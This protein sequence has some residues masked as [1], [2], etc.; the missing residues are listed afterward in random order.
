MFLIDME[1]WCV[2]QYESAATTQRT[3]RRSICKRLVTC[4]TFGIYLRVV[5]ASEQAIEDESMETNALVD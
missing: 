5:P 1:A 2:G 4:I 3:E